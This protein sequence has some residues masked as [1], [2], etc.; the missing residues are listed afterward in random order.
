MGWTPLLIKKAIEPWIEIIKQRSENIKA[1]KNLE[2]DL[3]QKYKQLRLA[4][5]QR[6]NLLH[7][8]NKQ[9]ICNWK[10]KMAKDLTEAE[11]QEDNVQSN[12]DSVSDL[13]WG[14]ELNQT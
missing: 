5:Y 7:N 2:S 8:I 1:V 13:D 3:M 14:L 4:I 10:K 6:A 11:L 12:A 9:V